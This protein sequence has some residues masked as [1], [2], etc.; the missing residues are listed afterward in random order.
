MSK[1]I[2]PERH[3]ADDAL[4]QILCVYTGV[5]DG[6]IFYVGKGQG[7]CIHQYEREADRYR[8]PEAVPCLSEPS[9]KI[10]A[11]HKT[12]A[13]KGKVVKTKVLETDDEQ[14]ANDY[15]KLFIGMCQN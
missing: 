8:Y 13:A 3:L 7:D 2:R 9:A 15:E 11:I 10:R 1:S 12:W 5:T 4:L 6:R 14:E